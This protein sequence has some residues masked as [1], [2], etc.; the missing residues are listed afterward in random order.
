MPGGLYQPAKGRV[1]GLGAAEV[2]P[3]VRVDG[4]E[5][6]ELVI[7]YSAH[8]RPDGWELYQADAS[9]RWLAYIAR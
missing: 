8:L 1:D 7:L 6:V 3:E 2:G 4:T 9:S 5:V